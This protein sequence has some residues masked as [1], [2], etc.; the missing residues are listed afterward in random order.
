[1]DGDFFEN[2]GGKRSATKR[3]PLLSFAE[4]IPLPC[5]GQMNKLLFCCK[6]DWTLK[7]V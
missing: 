1:M 6:R 5:A 3:R 2:T 7:K 4:P